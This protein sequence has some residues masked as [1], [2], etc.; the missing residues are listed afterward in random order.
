MTHCCRIVLAVVISITIVS[1]ETF[2]TCPGLDFKLSLCV[3][4]ASSHVRTLELLFRCVRTSIFRCLEFP[5]PQQVPYV[6]SHLICGVINSGLSMKTMHWDIKVYFPLHLLIKILRFHIPHSVRCQKA[7]V[8]L[9]ADVGENKRYCGKLEPF[10]VSFLSTKGNVTYNETSDFYYGYHF[11]LYYEGV[12][13]TQTIQEVYIISDKFIINNTYVYAGFHQLT[14][15]QQYM[16][17]A[18]QAKVFA[19]NIT[20]HV[21]LH[22]HDGPG[23]L[24]PVPKIYFDHNGFALLDFTASLG[25][26]AATVPFI[27]NGLHT[28]T[29]FENEY[30]VIRYSERD[31][32]RIYKNT[33]QCKL[34]D[35]GGMLVLT[36]RS[37]LKTTSCLW[38]TGVEMI[39]YVKNEL[40]VN[41][42]AYTGWDTF[43]HAGWGKEFSSNLKTHCQYGGLHI[44]YILRET[45]Y[46]ADFTSQMSIVEHVVNLCTNLT[47]ALPIPLKAENEDT[48]IDAYI[49]FSAYPGYGSGRFSVEFQSSQCNVSVRFGCNKKLVDNCHE[50]P[51]CK[52]RLVNTW[53]RSTQVPNCI[54]IWT[55]QSQYSDEL[56][57]E[58]CRNNHSKNDLKMANIL[59]SYEFLMD[60]WVLQSQSPFASRDHVPHFNVNLSITMLSDFPSHLTSFEV[61]K[62]NLKPYEPKRHPLLYLH[63]ISYVMNSMLDLQI[64][65]LRLQRNLICSAFH[66]NYTLDNIMHVFLE[67]T[68]HESALVPEH[69]DFCHVRVPSISRNSSVIIDHESSQFFLFAGNKDIQ[70]IIQLIPKMHCQHCL[71]HVAL[72]ENLD[73]NKKFRYTTWSNVTEVRWFCMTPYAFRLQ[74]NITRTLDCSDKCYLLLMFNYF[75][76][77]YK[78]NFQHY[79][80]QYYRV[81]KQATFMSWSEAKQSCLRLGDSLPKLTRDISRM[82]I[83]IKTGAAVNPFHEILFIDLHKETQVLVF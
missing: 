50:L 55:L 42:F 59:G 14:M 29:R 1:S 60:N 24:S 11:V 53:R 70:I 10:N 69:M 16:F 7:S 8:K 76:R 26:I 32:D 52:G 48:V 44:K 19:L 13:R 68:S 38:R 6:E 31:G 51:R 3:R 39:K 37:T 15:N 49:Y 54:D 28:D 2:G 72:W 78:S 67:G 9:A 46:F 83:Y 21:T 75:R 12:T 81:E 62:I 41:E 18:N 80:H 71:L 23:P 40:L 47:A 34:F 61:K 82:W 20:S 5:Q 33:S 25:Y 79:F 77:V 65:R 56:N 43:V 35:V 74:A 45:K 4:S 17:V 22:V 73:F 63:N 58:F 27:S 36:G 66:M 57:T 30:L 64:L